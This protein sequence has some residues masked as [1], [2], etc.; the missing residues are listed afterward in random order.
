MSSSPPY[1]TDSSTADGNRRQLEA[2]IAHANNEFN[3]IGVQFD[4][5][6][7]DRQRQDKDRQRLAD[8]VDH[9]N[10]SLEKMMK[11]IGQQSR[12]S[13]GK[14]GFEGGNGNNDERLK[15]LELAMNNVIQLIQEVAQQ[16]NDLETKVATVETDVREVKTN[17]ATVRSRLDEID[18]RLTKACNK[19][20]NKIGILEQGSTSQRQT[21]TDPLFGFM[22]RQL[23]MQ[24]RMRE[25][26]MLFSLMQGQ[27]QQCKPLIM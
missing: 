17:V 14:E 22:E 6:D 16:S 2:F 1:G 18:D 19:I 15:N 11:M 3:R 13:S 26:A 4:V 10:E 5:Q 23:N 9:L 20:T 21:D 8:Q 7:K 12:S 27:G 25:T 24:M